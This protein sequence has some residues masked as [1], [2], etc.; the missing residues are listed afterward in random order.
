MRQKLTIR[1]RVLNDV[2][3]NYIAKDRDFLALG[4]YRITRRYR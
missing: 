4:I 1:D 3:M 2:K